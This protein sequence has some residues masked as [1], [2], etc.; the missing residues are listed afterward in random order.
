MAQSRRPKTDL[1]EYRLW[2]T[3]SFI[4]E[5]QQSGEKIPRE[6]CQG[7]PDPWTEY[8]YPLPSAE[9]A[10]ALCKGCWFYENLNNVCL[11]NA[12]H[13]G[14]AWGVWG[15]VVFINGRQAHLMAEDDERLQDPDGGVDHEP[16]E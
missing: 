1:Y 8:G 9:E 3:Q 12:K 11:R 5:V 7:N 13:R 4:E 10:D 16:H 15:G 14:P 2:M 6:K